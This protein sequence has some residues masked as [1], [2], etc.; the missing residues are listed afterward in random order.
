MDVNFVNLA[1]AINLN[2]PAVAQVVK[3]NGIDVAMYASYA[4][5]MQ[6]SAMFAF[7]DVWYFMAYISILLVLYLPFMKRAK[8]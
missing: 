8:I 1:S 5:V 2:N 4:Q 3:S 6:Q 7:N